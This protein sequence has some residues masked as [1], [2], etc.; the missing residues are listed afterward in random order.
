MAYSAGQPDMGQTCSEPN[1][2]RA[3][4]VTRQV[5]YNTK[6]V[7]LLNLCE[8]AEEGKIHFGSHDFVANHG[9]TNPTPGIRG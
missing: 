5:Q 9:Q 6:H 8:R 7:H 4:L 3:V 1:C 2:S